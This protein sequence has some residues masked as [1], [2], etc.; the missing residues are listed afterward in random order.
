M[1]ELLTACPFV[2]EAW[3]RLQEKYPDVLAGGPRQEPTLCSWLCF[4]FAWKRVA[5][6]CLKPTWL[7]EHVRDCLGVVVVLLERYARAQTLDAPAASSSGS[8][9]LADLRT[10]TGRRKALDPM[11]FSAMTSSMRRIRGSSNVIAQVMAG[12]RSHADQILTMYSNRLYRDAMQE[13]LVDA[14]ALC[15]NWDPGSN[16]GWQWN[17]GLW[18]SASADIGGIIPPHVPRLRL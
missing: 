10:K 13:V 11:L 9:V 8:N 5:G 15:I 2:A 17:L 18:Y 12:R 1:G 14:P 3:R 16:A 7:Q 6:R 4:M